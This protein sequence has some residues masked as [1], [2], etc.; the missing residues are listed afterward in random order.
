MPLAAPGE[1]V[2]QQASLPEAL[3]SADPAIRREAARRFG[4]QTMDV[5]LREQFQETVPLLIEYLAD[6]DP[7]VVRSIAI[8]LGHLEDPRA[9]RPLV[10][11]LTHQD[12]Q[13]RQVAGGVL[14]HFIVPEAVVPL[15]EVLPDPRARPM[16]LIR[17]RELGARVPV[18]P[19]IEA[20][21]HADPEVRQG[22]AEALAIRPQPA[23]EA[24]PSLIAALADPKGGVRRAAA[25]ALGRSGSREAV[26]ALI[27]RLSDP[28][29]AVR[30][31]TARALGKGGREAVSPLLLRLQDQAEEAEVRLQ[32]ASSLRIIGD[33]SPAPAM[34]AVLADDS[35]AVRGELARIL[36]HWDKDPDVALAIIDGLG[37]DQPRIRRGAATALTID[38]HKVLTLGQEGANLLLPLVV[39]SDVVVRRAAAQ[40][41]G[42]LAAWKLLP[43][44]ASDQ[45][46]R[47]VKEE[48]DPAT[49]RWLEA[50]LLAER[51]T[52]EAAGR[53]GQGSATEKPAAP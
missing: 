36:S 53:A 24:V 32:A 27:A 41:I 7:E 42:R 19:L 51:R 10:K 3:K 40:A 18:A 26:P 12:S 31:E 22:A 14:E 6:P 21:A 44:G 15:L 25:E 1:A 37:S 35:P 52:G 29:V 16:A 47:Q 45:L 28:E 39:S 2:A 23:P 30:L 9:M 34:V 33:S 43:E 5:R 46:R 4:G 13:V 8:G 48:S 38:L 20:L 11:L 17:L 49:R 50:A